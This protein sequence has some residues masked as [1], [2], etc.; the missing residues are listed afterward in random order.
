MPISN[1]RGPLNALEH[2]ER[3]NNEP[4][5]L[6]KFGQEF[7]LNDKP[8]R[9]YSRK[10][11][12][13]QRPTRMER[14]RSPEPSRRIQLT[15]REEKC[16]TPPDADCRV[17]CSSSPPLSSTPIPIPS[18]SVTHQD[19]VPARKK[20]RPK[21]RFRS[22]PSFMPRNLTETGLRGEQAYVPG[23]TPP[24]YYLYSE[25]CNMRDVDREEEKPVDPDDEN[26][27]DGKFRSAS[28]SDYEAEGHFNPFL[29]DLDM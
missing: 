20:P 1:G 18:F 14:K 2:Q 4:N 26:D 7:F 9:S 27:R 3:S 28:F 24:S 12:A 5:D 22:V 8:K 16:R 17:P 10:L 11:Q 21:L 19:M 6:L 29:A 23:A 13:K 15:D 25:M